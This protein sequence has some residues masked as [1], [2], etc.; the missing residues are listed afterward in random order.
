MC[1]S[2]AAGGGRSW[3]REGEGRIGVVEIEKYE[4]IS[5]RISSCFFCYKEVRIKRE[6]GV[7][8]Y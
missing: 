4:F 8:K 1:V 5:A 2:R 3:E 7:S 6:R